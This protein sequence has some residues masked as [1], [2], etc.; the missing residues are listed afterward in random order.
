MSASSIPLWNL[1]EARTAMIV[2]VESNL[3]PRHKQRMSELGLRP[4]ELIRS[5][6]H[7]I[8][9]GPRLF[10]VAGSIFSIAREIADQVQVRVIESNPEVGHS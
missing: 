1:P 9:G 7:I 5:Q 8:F 4:G 2:T 6:Q 10:Q 3:D